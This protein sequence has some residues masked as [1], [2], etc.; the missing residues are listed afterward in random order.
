MFVAR[1]SAPPTPA[2]DRPRVSELQFGRGRHAVLVHQTRRSRLRMAAGMD[3]DVDIPD[4]A[5]EDL[6]VSPDLARYTNSVAIDTETMG[7]DPHRD[8]L[9]V[10]QLSPGDGSADVARQHRGVTV[11]D[12]APPP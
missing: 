8:R 7:L 2:M 10:V 11:R 3:H 6:E 1:P 9:C 4:T 5:S 12:A